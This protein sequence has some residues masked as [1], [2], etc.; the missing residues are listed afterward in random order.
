MAQVRHR[1]ASKCNSYSYNTVVCVSEREPDYRIH[2]I[3][4]LS[5]GLAYNGDVLTFPTSL[6]IDQDAEY[7]FVLEVRKGSRV[8]SF[9]L[10]LQNVEVRPPIMTVE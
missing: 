3:A 10:T 8:S 7:E 5:G 9:S 1:Q 6:F 2:S 4:F